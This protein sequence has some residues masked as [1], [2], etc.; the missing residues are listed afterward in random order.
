MTKPYYVE[1]LRCRIEIARKVVLLH[2]KISDEAEAARQLSFSDPLT[3]IGN[4]R[5]GDRA[6]KECFLKFE[7]AG[8]KFAA[9]LIDIDNFKNIN[10]LYGHDVGDKILVEVAEKIKS[11]IRSI[12][13]ICRWGGE[14]FLVVIKDLNENIGGDFLLNIAERIR[15]TIESS[16]WSC[17]QIEQITVSMGLSLIKENDTVSTFMK[18][19]DDFLYESKRLG[20][21]RVTSDFI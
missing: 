4:R 2:D 1:E 18:R 12:D 8:C 5:C 3:H 20:K 9:L 11:E 10:D 15:K 19:I 7:V 16:Q 13:G 17:D 21:N 14:E 6:L